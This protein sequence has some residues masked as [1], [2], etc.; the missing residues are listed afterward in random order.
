MI[1]SINKA[2][3]GRNYQDKVNIAALE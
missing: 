1:S 2:G 3:K